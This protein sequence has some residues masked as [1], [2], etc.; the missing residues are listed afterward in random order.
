MARSIFNQA[1]FLSSRISVCWIL[2]FKHLVTLYIRALLIL[3][4]I[5]F[6]FA[7]D[8]RRQIYSNPYLIS[9]RSKDLSALT[10]P[11]SKFRYQLN[12]LSVPSLAPRYLL[13]HLPIYESEDK[14][15]K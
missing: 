9:I 10:Y 15:N 1:Q 13:S 7:S 6:F 2:S 8:S 4:H 12:C 14:E 5:A 3:I 11:R